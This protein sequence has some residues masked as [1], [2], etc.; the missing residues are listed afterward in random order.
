MKRGR[1]ARLIKNLDQKKGGGVTLQSLVAPPPPVPTLLCNQFTLVLQQ[2]GAMFSNQKKGWV[3]CICKISDYGQFCDSVFYKI[4]CTCT[5][6][7][8]YDNHPCITTSAVVKFPQGSEIFN[9][10]FHNKK[11]YI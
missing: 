3:H 11:I 10:L 2:L 7:Q 6:V 1:G 9:N 8:R 4:N 5:H